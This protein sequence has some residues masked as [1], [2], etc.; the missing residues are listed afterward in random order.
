MKKEF[1][2]FKEFYP[3]YIDEHKNKYTK[4][5]HFIGSWFF[6]YFIANLVMTGDFKFLAYAL[7]AGYGWA[8]FGHFLLKKT[9]L[10]L[11]N[12]PF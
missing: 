9:N 2:N 8:W 12:P 4:L 7:I 6:F 11:L 3:F 1:A 5:T 10:P